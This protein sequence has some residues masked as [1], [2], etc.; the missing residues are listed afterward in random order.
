MLTGTETETTA[1]DSSR[2]ALARRHGLVDLGRLPDRIRKI[3]G[4]W[5]GSA[6]G[7]MALYELAQRDGLIGSIDT[8]R[9]EMSQVHNPRDRE[10]LLVWLKSRMA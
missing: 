10:E 8:L 5:G 3:A 6:V 1:A 2:G 9:T 4:F 7:V